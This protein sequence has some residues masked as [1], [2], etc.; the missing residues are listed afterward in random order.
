MSDFISKKCSTYNNV[1]EFIEQYD[2][3]SKIVDYLIKDLRDN[4]TS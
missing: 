3:N 4:N 2:K 1:L